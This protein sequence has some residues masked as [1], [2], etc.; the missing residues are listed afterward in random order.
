MRP[1]QSIGEDSKERDSVVKIVRKCGEGAH[2]YVP[3]S[4]IDKP[5]EVIQLEITP[6]SFLE[7][8][9]GKH[10]TNQLI[11][12]VDNKP[13]K[14]FEPDPKPDLPQPDPEYDEEEETAG[15]DKG[16]SETT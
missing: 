6:R 11:G 4:W 10:I 8:V 2:V 15:N 1:V 13:W 9:L 5:V 16:D 7:S 12:D 3:R 14:P